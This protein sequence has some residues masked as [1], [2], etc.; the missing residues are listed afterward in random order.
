MQQFQ[1][2]NNIKF[3]KGNQVIGPY[4][5][6]EIILYSPLFKWYLVLSTRRIF[7]PECAFKQFADEVSCARRA[8]DV[9]QAYEIIAETMQLPGHCGC[10]KTITN[11][12]KMVSTT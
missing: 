2:K 6:K 1:N 8:G 7:T 4:L 3:S 11:T 5:A 12:E 10:G 9:D